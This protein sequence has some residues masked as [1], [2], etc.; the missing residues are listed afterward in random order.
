MKIVKTPIPDIL[1]VDVSRIGD[2]RGW[3]AQTW[4]RAGLEGHG[5]FVDWAQENYV[6][7]YAA[8][9]LRGLHFQAPP[10][11]Q[12]KLILVTRGAIHD[13]VLDIRR[14]S[15]TFGRHFAVQLDSRKS[16]QL[17]VP[18]GFAHGFLTLEPE[19][20]VLYRLTVAYAPEAEGGL[21]WNDPALQI[22][23]PGDP[24]SI[25]DR[26]RSWPSF[27]DF[28]TPFSYGSGT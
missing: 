25:N 6:H 7:S 10:Y 17:W 3:L 13:V 5:I 21:C 15:P 1:L 28:R 4:S 22:E 19:T 26:D 11:A 12:G 16:V 27:A 18:P 2:Q 20:E 8:G 14:G 23:W 24:G 9:T